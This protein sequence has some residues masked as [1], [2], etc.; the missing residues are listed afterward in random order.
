[1]TQKQAES[2]TL[3]PATLSRNELSAWLDNRAREATKFDRDKLRWDLVPWDAMEP[4]VRVLT[5]GAKKYGDR[6][7]EAAFDWSRPY[8]ALLRHVTAWFRGEDNDP[9]SG[10]SH[11]AHAACNILFMLAFVLRGR[12]IDNRPKHV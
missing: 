10:I 4:V 5:H 11:L 8:A 1:M 7:W 6:N 9:E 2:E 12:G 3:D